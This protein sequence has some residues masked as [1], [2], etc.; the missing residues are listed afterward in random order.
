MAGAAIDLSLQFL[1]FTTVE[2]DLEIFVIDVT[3]Q[4]VG[5]TFLFLLILLDDG[6]LL[7][8]ELIDC[9]LALVLLKFDFSNLFSLHFDFFL[10]VHAEIFQG[11][12][13]TNQM[14]LL[15]F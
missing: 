15:H 9:M 10:L 2:F 5:P 6:F 4:I 8:L 12:K 1:H 13:L 11:I 3:R 14:L 7:L